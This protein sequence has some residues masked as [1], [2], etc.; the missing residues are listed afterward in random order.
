LDIYV[1]TNI[2]LNVIYKEPMFKSESADLLRKIQAEDIKATTSAVTFLEI[3]LDMA[4]RGFADQ[5]EVAIS[6]VE[7]LRGLTIAQLDKTMSTAAATHVLKDNI[8]IHDAYHLATALH[9]KVTHFVTRDIALSKKIRT[10]IDVIT[11][12]EVSSVKSW[13]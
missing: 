12:E 7:D 2:F 5:T 1:D 11:P 13:G 8:T 3:I 9:S 10:Y 6:S 4:R